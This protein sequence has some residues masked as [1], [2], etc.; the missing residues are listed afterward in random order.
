LVDTVVVAF[1]VAF[2]YTWTAKVG[3]VEIWL[4][5]AA[6][7]SNYA[8]RGGDNSTYQKRYSIAVSSFGID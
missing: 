5:S 4:S 3:T 8:G 7:Y 6:A 1:A 2:K